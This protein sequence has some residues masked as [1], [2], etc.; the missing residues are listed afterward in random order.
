MLLT[1]D[2]ADG[3]KW[4][5][6]HIF[7]C[8]QMRNWFTVNKPTLFTRKK[9]TLNSLRDGELSPNFSTCATLSCL[10]VQCNIR[11]GNRDH[12]SDTYHEG[13]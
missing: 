6:L 13:N 4:V 11:L 7:K 10:R 8:K 9:C 2:G 12:A 5:H 1:D 3:L